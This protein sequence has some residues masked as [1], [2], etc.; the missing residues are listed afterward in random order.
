MTSQQLRSQPT[1]E[2]VFDDLDIITF[3]DRKIGE[4][5]NFIARELCGLTEGL[6]NRHLFLDF[7]NIG[8]INSSE[9]GTLITLHRD[10]KA[11]GGRLILV[12]VNSHVGEVLE[13]TN[14]HNL[15]EVRKEGPEREVNYCWI[16]AIPNPDNG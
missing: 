4:E 11:A 5:E 15:F 10:M 6:S 2:H 3:T 7:S 16:E 13:R 9:L 12:K 14:L 8:Y 1:M